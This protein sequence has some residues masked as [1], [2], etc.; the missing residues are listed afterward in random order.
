GRFPPGGHQLR[1]ADSRLGPAGH[2]G[3]AGGTEPGLGPA[4]PTV[5]FQT[6][7]VGIR[8]G[9]QVGGRPRDHPFRPPWRRR[10]VL[11]PLPATTPY[12]RKTAAPSGWARSPTERLA[13]SARWTHW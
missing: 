4:A 8:V 6:R 10:C 13:H 1:R 7:W 12:R 5:A 2:P 11:E 3:A 9:G